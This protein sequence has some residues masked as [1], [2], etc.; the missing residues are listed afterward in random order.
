MKILIA[1]DI[2]GS[3]RFCGELVERIAEECPDTILLLGDLLY[4][5]PRNALPEGYDPMAVSDMLNALKE[6]IIA[7]RGNCEAEVDQMVLEFP[8]MADY[9][10]LID[11]A[12]RT[13]FATH[14]H[15]WNPDNLPYL[16]PGSAFLFGHTHVKQLEEKTGVLLVNPGSISIPKDGSHSYAV[17]EDGTFALKTLDG[18]TI[19][20]S[21]LPQ[22]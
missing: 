13:L 19:E 2:H 16:A 3:A 17:Y 21:C 8:C 5:G 18:K 1:S 11:S 22:T 7:V 12:G 15:L 9:S 10:S 6:H 14:G 4:H 20:T